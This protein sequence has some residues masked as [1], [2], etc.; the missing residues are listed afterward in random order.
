MQSPRLNKSCDQCR[1]RKVRCIVPP[2]QPRHV[3]CTH[4]IKR[5]ETCQFSNLK[6]RLRAKDPSTP[7]KGSSNPTPSA[8]LF[9][10]HLMRNPSESAVLY[11]EFS[12]LKAHDDRV[13]SSG[14]AFFSPKRVDSLVKRL[15]DTRLEDLIHQID[16]TIRTRLLAR[17]EREISLY[18]LAKAPTQLEVDPEADSHVQRYFEV[19]HPIYPFLD[20]RAFEEK[21]RI[22]N[23][24][25]LLGTD[26]A[27]CGLY[28]A[29]LAL[30]CQY[31]GFSSFIPDNNRAW[32]FFQISLSRLD[33]I[34]TSS[35]SLANLQALTAMALFATSAFGHQLDR[36][37]L[38]AASRMVLA[39]RYHKSILNEDSALCHRIFW[40]IYHLEKRYSFQAGTSSVIA[41]CDIG[42]PIQTAPESMIGGY[43][44]LL[45]SVRYSRILSIAYA[46]LFSVSASTHSDDTLLAS[47][48]HVHSVLEEWRQ[49]I[50]LEFRPKEPLQ[51]RRL[52]DGAS[53]EIAL[54]TH[55][56]YYH[57]I[58]ALER[59]T[60]HVS[61]DIARSENAMRAL[62]NTAREVINLTRFID[63]EPYT[64]VFILAILPLSALFILFDFVIHHPSDPETRGY[65]TLLDIVAGHFSQLDHASSGAIPSSY[66]S[67]F[68]HM[69]R[70]YV[71]TVQRK[72][73]TAH[74]APLSESSGGLS[75]THT[76]TTAAVET[77]SMP[78]PA[79]GPSDPALMEGV[80]ES[81]LDNL[82]FLTPDSDWTV[83]MHSLEE[84]DPR[85]FYG[86]IFL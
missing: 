6:R 36:P 8:E 22:S 75:A 55:Y 77:N 82:Y 31:D 40:V 7:Q 49:S 50:P 84:F 13:P 30:G 11:D 34:L 52:I 51:R 85:E 35:E 80:D 32:K 78:N 41:D 45:S 9:I 37:L 63:V 42:C 47:V 70:Q 17:P 62:L 16:K 5:N 74:N 2:A 24:L 64:P 33:Q 25:H 71:Q 44:W 79:M 19:L 67:E 14:I 1:S 72:P 28:Y 81:S 65:L 58:I 68:S 59:L 15:A 66:L 29:I 46:S 86:S 3:A 23:V 57:I 27:F 83:G 20:R 73:D 10:D 43:N 54:R 60:L 69:A 21:A 18:T 76:T 4:C 53:K 26:Y 12:I 39:L 38:A 48:D 61:R 56:Y